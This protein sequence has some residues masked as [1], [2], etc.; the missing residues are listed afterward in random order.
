MIYETQT[1]VCQAFHKST[2]CPS[3]PIDLHIIG[4]AKLY[5]NSII[6][7]QHNTSI[8]KKHYFVEDI[9]EWRYIK[10]VSQ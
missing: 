3:G 2:G 9:Y 6:I 10:D 7:C 8:D 5:P 4:H 1:R